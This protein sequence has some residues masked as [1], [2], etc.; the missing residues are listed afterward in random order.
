MYEKS[1]EAYFSK[2]N[3]GLIIES[4][5][6][7]I[8][9]M[10][11][12]IW[13]K[14]PVSVKNEANKIKKEISNELDRFGK[15][16]SKELNIES[17]I[18]GL[19]FDSN[20]SSVPIHFDNKL[21][22]VIKVNSEKSGTVEYDHDYDKSV[23]DII[24]TK[25]G[26][27]FKKPDNKKFIITIGLGLFYI[28]NLTI[29]EATGV[30]LHELGHCFQRL[31]DQYTLNAYWTER[32]NCIEDLY[33]ALTPVQ[34]LLDRFTRGKIFSMK[35]HKYNLKIIL[36]FLTF[37]KPLAKVLTLSSTA[38]KHGKDVVGQHLQN[39]TFGSIN[40]YNKYKKIDYDIRNEVGKLI[41][42]DTDK[43]LDTVLNNSQDFSGK[44]FNIFSVVLKSIKNAFYNLG[45]VIYY[46]AKPLTTL[47]FIPAATV[48]AI[49]NKDMKKYRKFEE[50]ADH[51]ATV[52]GYGPEL[53]N[54]LKKITG[55]LL[56]LGALNFVH[57]V[58]GLNVWLSLSKFIEVKMNS[59]LF[60]YPTTKERIANL[61]K[62]LKYELQNNPDISNED[63]EKIISE[64]EEIN[65][66]F[67]DYVHGSGLKGL[68]YS[69]YN[70]LIGMNIEKMNTTNIEE[71][72]LKVLSKDT[73]NIN[74]DEIKN[75]LNN[76]IKEMSSK[77]MPGMPGNPFPPPGV[78]GSP[79]GPPIGMGIPGMPFLNRESLEDI[80][81][82]GITE[83]GI[84]GLNI[85]KMADVDIFIND[86]LIT[87]SNYKKNNY[88]GKLNLETYK[89]SIGME[90]GATLFFKTL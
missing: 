32:K 57:I 53:A 22:K 42:K 24:E 63:K 11:D 28:D 34:R 64:M 66:Y 33:T 3:L 4:H 26:Y 74:D 84:E 8:K 58:P 27:K 10:F 12:N 77:F 52:Y 78:P 75:N 65:K 90:N 48:H 87:N 17:C 39:Q 47:S 44:K 25:N 49:Y 36:E 56:D 80:M 1:Q 45:R 73:S 9:E 23:S 88:Y 59:S 85:F 86:K 70:R 69:I 31:V 21:V 29:P 41:N 81:G 46:T 79:Y 71:N 72:V 50:F 37:F 30:V 83:K 38:R 7:N 2:S 15:D 5:L 89:E 35:N 20:A 43:L 61:Y 19:E 55:N 18:I 62:T 76:V 6:E 60:G 67:N 51:F 68:V 13:S 16:L 14:D 82:V 54:G 40:V